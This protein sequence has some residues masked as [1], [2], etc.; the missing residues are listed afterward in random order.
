MRTMTLCTALA[1]LF[2][3]GLP[4]CAA[5][6]DV[7]SARQFPVTFRV[8]NDDGEPVAGA[9]IAAGKAPLGRTTSS[10]TLNVKLAGTEGQMIPVTITCP[11]G[12]SSPEKPAELR[13]SRNRRLDSSGYLPSLLEGRCLRTTRSIV[14]VVRA[15]GS[16]ELPVLVDGEPSGTTNADG[17]AHLLVHAPRTVR[18]LTVA[19]DTSAHQRLRP[20]DPSRKYELSGKDAVLV[21][22]QP[23]TTLPSPTPRR[24]SRPHR[25]IP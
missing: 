18:A 24:S 21:F 4:G 2:G 17:I 1:F 5:K 23:L 8:T 10:G 6:K 3:L 15:V 7:P 16:P 13:L 12:Y 14:L 19:L 11:D 22:D 20:R 9:R 25:H